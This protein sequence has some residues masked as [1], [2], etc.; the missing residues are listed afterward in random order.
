MAWAGWASHKRNKD[1]LLAGRTSGGEVSL[2]CPPVPRADPLPTH[3]II[4]FLLLLRTLNT[5]KHENIRTSYPLRIMTKNK[6]PTLLLSPFP[7]NI[8][9]NQCNEKQHWTSLNLQLRYLN[10]HARLQAQ[11]QSQTA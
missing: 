2:S 8:K 3:A 7:C 1:V 6:I 5:Y 4:T 11:T 9:K 10:E